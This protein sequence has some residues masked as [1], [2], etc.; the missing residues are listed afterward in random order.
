M[1]VDKPFA[2]CCRTRSYMVVTRRSALGGDDLA[3]LYFDVIDVIAGRL[4]RRVEGH[5]AAGT[6]PL[7]RTKDLRKPIGIGCSAALL[8]GLSHNPHAFEA[9]Q[10]DLSRGGAV[11][12]LIGLHELP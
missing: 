9:E 2:I 4:P 7:V 10:F 3:V 1:P 8:H 6:R 11:L 12:R 5:R